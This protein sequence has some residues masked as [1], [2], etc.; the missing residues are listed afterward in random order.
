MESFM[1]NTAQIVK[2]SN[3]Y[4]VTT[5]PNDVTP[6]GAVQTYCANLAAVTTLLQAAPL[7]WT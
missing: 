1:N 4:V 5:Y 7:S 6:A 2:I 3:G